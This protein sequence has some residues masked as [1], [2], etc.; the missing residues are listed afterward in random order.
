[1]NAE[2]A[3]RGE[4][5]HA[6]APQGTPPPRPGKVGRP[7]KSPL[8]KLMGPAPRIER[9]R[10]WCSWDDVEDATLALAMLEEGDARRARRG[11]G[12]TKDDVAKALGVTPGA[13]EH[14]EIGRRRPAL[15]TAIQLGRMLLEFERMAAARRANR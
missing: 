2:Q 13:L 7:R 15:G 12:F 5:A 6:A 10:V 14:W 11:A 4:P 9:G 1:M 8:Q 3:P